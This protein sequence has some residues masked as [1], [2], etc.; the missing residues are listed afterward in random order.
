MCAGTVKKQMGR[1][2]DRKKG[3]LDVERKRL[4]GGLVLHPGYMLE[5]AVILAALRRDMLCIRTKGGLQ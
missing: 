5:E 1:K 3:K 2:K 4:L